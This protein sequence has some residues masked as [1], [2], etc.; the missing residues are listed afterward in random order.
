MEFSKPRV[1]ASKLPSHRGRNVC[2]LG[3]V[4]NVAND[5]NSFTLTTSDSQD[6]RVVLQEPVNE[7]VAG[8]TE[9]HGQV[10]GQNNILCQ[11]YIV[12]PSE[13]SDNFASPSISGKG[14]V[15]EYDTVPCLRLSKWPKLADSWKSRGPY[16]ERYTFNSKWKE[17]L[18]NVV[19][20]FLVPT[21]N[22]MSRNKQEQFRLSF[23]MV[24]IKCFDQ[25]TAKMRTNYGIAKYAF[26]QLFCSES[27]DLLSSYHIKPFSFGL[28]KSLVLMTGTIF[29]Q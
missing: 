21:G 2:L 1:N 15:N 25:L 11:N 3:K 26:K 27:Y 13:T 23:S 8:L 22:P 10:D 9:V 12:F 14:A 24:E 5:G 29:H 16:S 17:A 4:K 19:P 18:V 28:L 20:L 6:V 7:Y